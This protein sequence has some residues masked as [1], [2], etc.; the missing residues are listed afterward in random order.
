MIM[1]SMGAHQE[2]GPGPTGAPTDVNLYFPYGDGGS[3]GT[4]EDV[5]IGVVWANSDPDAGVQVGISDDSGEPDADDQKVF[6]PAGTTTFDIT[7]QL[8]Y[9]FDDAEAERVYVR[10][11]RNG[12]YSS[13]VGPATIL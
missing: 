3:S 10:H 2:T 9:T 6:L 1:S 5:E 8:G 11:A 13:W 7:A 12:Q 4:G